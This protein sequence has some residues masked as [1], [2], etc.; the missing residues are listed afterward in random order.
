[1]VYGSI[2][3]KFGFWAPQT[4]LHHWFFAQHPT[5][6]LV[7]NGTGYFSASSMIITVIVFVEIVSLDL[8][9]VEHLLMSSNPNLDPEFQTCY[10]LK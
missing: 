4:Y 7:K 5:Q 2:T 1:M 6:K 10:Y 8:I 3:L 9:Q